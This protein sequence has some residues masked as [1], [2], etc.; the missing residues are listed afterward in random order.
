MQ[1]MM[2]HAQSR[3]SQRRTRGHVDDRIFQLQVSSFWFLELQRRMQR[4]IAESS[5]M[6]AGGG[7]G[8]AQHVIKNCLSLQQN[9]TDLRPAGA[10]Q[11][12][13]LA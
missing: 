5:G 12:R 11:Q 4:R 2:V 8:R 9:I 13:P 3:I 1:L 6:V 10:L 7:V